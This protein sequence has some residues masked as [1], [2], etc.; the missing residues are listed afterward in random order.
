MPKIKRIVD[1]SMPIFPGMSRP[2]VIRDF[3]IKHVATIEKDGVDVSE[4]VLSAHTGTHFD[5]PLHFVG[6]GKTVDQVGLE[7]II[8]EAVILDLTKLKP[9]Q[10][11]SQKDLEPFASKIRPKDIVLLHTGSDK[12]LNK[13]EYA[14]DYP[15][16]GASAARWLV[17][18]RISVV[19]V[20]FMAV[21]AL[22]KE[23]LTLDAHKTL[24]GAGLGVV[25]C[26]TN[27]GGIRSERPL[28]IAAPLKIQGGD[29]SPVRALAIE[30]E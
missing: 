19:G 18:K 26:L 7:T 4:I 16:I 5:A 8:G 9:K 25:E 28:F 1:L 6:S 23:P 21:D 14:T 17:E 15:F 30:F 11:I 3:E 20:D 27:L 29:A 12:W 24:L 2:A 10:E 13:P 22:S